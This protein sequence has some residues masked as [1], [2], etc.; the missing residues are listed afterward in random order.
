LTDGG[1]GRLIATPI[2]LLVV[3]VISALL[4]IAENVDR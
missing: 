3:A 1:C 2:E 4:G